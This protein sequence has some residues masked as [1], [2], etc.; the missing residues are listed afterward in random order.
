MAQD[1]P[2]EN[3]PAQ[4]VAKDQQEADLIN[5]L[6]KQTDMNQ[7]LQ[8]LNT[9]TQKYPDT[10]F[11][12]ERDQAYLA[13]Y[14]H[15]PGKSQEAFNKA[16]EILAKHPNDFKALYTII[17]YL[18]TLNNG[19]PSAADMDT[20]EQTANHILKNADTIFADSNKPADIAADQWPKVKDTTL[21][22]AQKTIGLIYFQKKDWPRAE[23]ELT[24]AM[25][26]DPMQGQVAYL[27]ATA[28]FNQRQ[29]DPKKQPP[30]IF[31]FA[32]AAA[33]EGANA[34]PAQMRTQ[35]QGS[36]AK[37]YKSYHGSDEGYND[38]VALAKQ[39]PLPPAGWTIESTADIASKKA[40]AQAA[41]DAANPMMALWRNIREQLTG[42]GGAAY[43]DGTV[44]DAAL[45]GGANGV[46]KF[47][48][49]IV[50][51]T[52]AVRPK[53]I[54]LAIEKPEGDVTLKLET[55]LPG[56]MEPGE[57]LEFEGVAKAFTKD[58]FMLTFETEK[59]KISGWT[60]KNT[61]P[62]KKAVPKKAAQ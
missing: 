3:K 20:G 36:T 43:F 29:Q 4:K 11:A 23:V 10:Q 33:Y 41:A 5:S 30:A 25:Q 37:M 26:A 7:L 47:K 57:E 49:K 35:L 56:K 55:A 59:D 58:P 18:P 28:M 14:Q 44:K 27:L 19:N 9:W 32:R 31:E 51:M 21:P 45:P 6:P 39:N 60:G 22:L 2:A 53:E 46:T 62:V 42:E 17:A 54:V 48:G 8:I 13:C 12:D 16:K 15:M 61:A 50:S 52:P 24:K 1:K 34:L 40:A 38:V